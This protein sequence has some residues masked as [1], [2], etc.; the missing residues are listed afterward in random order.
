MKFAAKGLTKAIA[1][2]GMLTA[3]SAL[4]A[5]ED[6]MPSLPPAVADLLASS[7]PDERVLQLSDL[8]A[9]DQGIWKNAYHEVCPGVVKGGFSGK[10]GEYAVLLVPSKPDDRETRAV[11]VLPKEGGG[12][13]QK[14]IY[15]E[16]RVGNLPVIRRSAPGVYKDLEKRV[17]LTAPNEVLLIEHLEGKVT[18]IAFVNGE[19]RTLIIAE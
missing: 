5:A 3:L 16:Q 11:L 18:A 12:L 14:Q 2:L 1:A 9:D 15:A 13:M 7:Y 10:K 17:K 8:N 6:C 19:M 4:A